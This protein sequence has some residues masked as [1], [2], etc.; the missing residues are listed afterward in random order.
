MQGRAC[1][2]RRWLD[3][4]SCA[5][6]ENREINREFLQTPRDSGP[7]GWFSEL[8]AKRIQWLAAD[9]LFLVKTGNSSY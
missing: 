9:S 3:A 2:R 8:L 7:F 5:F 1:S 6:P 4:A